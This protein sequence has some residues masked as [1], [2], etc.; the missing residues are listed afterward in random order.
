[1]VWLNGNSMRLVVLGIVAVIVLGVT[2]AKADFTF[3]EPEN[4]GPNDNQVGPTVNLNCSHEYSP[5]VS[6]DGLELYFGSERAG[7]GGHMDLW[8][9]T[10]AMVEDEWNSAESQGPGTN[11]PKPYQDMNPC[12]S[13]DWLELHFHSDC[14]NGATLGLCG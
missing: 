2:S 8:V 5:C 6:A 12:L 10:R 13:A 9:S 1:M 3:G 4:L 7:G 14:Y 11:S